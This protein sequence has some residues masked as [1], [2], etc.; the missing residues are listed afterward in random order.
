VDGGLLVQGIYSTNPTIELAKYDR[1]GRRHW[2]TEIRTGKESW[3]IGRPATDGWG[4]IYLMTK[5]DNDLPCVWRV[6]PAGNQGQGWLA[7]RAMG[8]ALGDE[9]KM[10]V[11]RNAAVW[12]LGRGTMAR[13]FGPDGR[14]CFISEA[15]RAA[16]AQG[17]RAGDIE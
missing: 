11:A 9:D 3:A 1:S 8:G 4:N 13:G 6:D 2:L 17:R 14:V 5:L 12:M 16:D 7:T 15:S 10:L